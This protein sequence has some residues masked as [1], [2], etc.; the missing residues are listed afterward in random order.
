MTAGLFDA[1]DFL[2]ISDVS[3]SA[4]ESVLPYAIGL[5]AILIGLKFGKRVLA[6][7]GVR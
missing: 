1:T 5:F 4:I 7:F 6:K 2:P 3:I